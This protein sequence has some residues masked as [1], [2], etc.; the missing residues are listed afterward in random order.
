MQ[1]GG[2]RTGRSGTTTVNGS[3]VRFQPTFSWQPGE[4]V[5]TVLTTTVQNS[6]GLFLSRPRV[7]QFTAATAGGSGRFAPGSDVS[8]TFTESIATADLDGDGDLDLLTAQYH[9][10]SVNVQFNNGAGQY[11][12]SSSVVVGLALVSNPFSVSTADLDGDGDI[13]FVTANND[14]VLHSASVRFNDGTG[15]FSGGS[16]LF[17]GSN[18][19]AVT[20][21]DVDGD[22]DLDVL[23]A[24]SGPG[25]NSVSVRFNTGSG[26]FSGGSEAQVGPG[27]QSIAMGDVDGDGDLDL[28][29]TSYGTFGNPPGTTVSVRLNNGSGTFAG[30][31]EVPV[32]DRP[33]SIATA[34]VDADG[35]LDFLSVSSAAVGLVNVR[36][37]DGTGRFTNGPDV[38]VGAY[39]HGVTTGDVDGDGDLDLL[40]ANYTTG[41]SGG[42]T[43][44]VRLNDGSGG[45]TGGSEVPTAT[46]PWCVVTGDVDGDGDLDLLTGNFPGTTSV[47]LNQAAVPAP[48]LHIAGDSLLC[49]SGQVRLTASSTGTVTAYRWNTGA[50]TASIVVT[51][52]GL[53]TVTATFTGGLTNTT[54]YRVHSLAPTVRIAGDTVQYPGRPT[55]LSALAPG[56]RSLRWSTGDSTAIIGVLTPG[57]Y[58]VTAFYGSGCQA[59]AHV[60]VSAPQVHITGLAVVCTGTG[61]HLNAVA[62]GAS[63]FQWDGGTA[64]PALTVS[65]PGT[66]RVVVTFPNG[67]T[68]TATQR[69]SAPLVRITGDTLLCP[70]Q[71]GTLRAPAGATSY[72]W[73]TGATTASLAVTQPERY[74]VTVAYGGC[75][76][77][78]QVQVQALAVAPAYTLGADTTLCEGE[79]L[80]LRVRGEVPGTV[81]YAW[82]DGFATPTRRV[83]QP[84]VY[85][86]QLH[87][88]CSTQTLSRRIT[89]RP[90]LVFPNIITPNGDRANERFVIQGLPPEGAALTL[91]NRWGT[92]VYATDAYH[93]DWGEHAAPG[94]YFYVLH[95]A[96]SGTF[97]KGWVEVMR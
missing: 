2:L 32:A 91:Y 13:D 34:D 60:L 66:Y 77:V 49:N 42:G 21:A 90:C 9:G 8:T 10:N 44:S 59:R 16:E 70:G 4:T 12:F 5:Q 48:A 83:Q 64:G 17:V 19:V 78:A 51:Q 97:Y 14:A 79:S 3:T 80:V 58:T 57:T 85:S 47:R 18:P 7:Q 26:T 11:A 62:P 93:N 35:D 95:R 89:Y 37:N 28:L 63:S 88:P 27:P 75:T 30:T 20:T 61:T 69:V 82:T 87:L 68:A 53:Y 52:P 43:V 15:H 25:S 56:A 96:G 23:V 46:G 6:A 92:P 86:L 39:P 38:P 31:R 45:F 72:R 94:V 65:Q 54:R 74:S 36:V 50:T 67:C 41:T 84:G 29:T 55:Q 1:R 40:T 22:G 33:F 81:R 24:N 71:T 76:A 73:N